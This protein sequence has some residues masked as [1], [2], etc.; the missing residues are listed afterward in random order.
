M[1]DVAPVAG[2]RRK[3]VSF[4]M[5][6][7]DFCFLLII[8]FVALLSVA[9]FDPTITDTLAVKRTASGAGVPMDGQDPVS[10]SG[11]PLPEV[12]D[13]QAQQQALSAAQA[14]ALSLSEELAGL[15]EEKSH[16]QQQLAAL[17]DSQTTTADSLAQQAHRAAASE[18]ELNRLREQVEELRVKVRRLEEERKVLEEALEKARQ[19]NA[20]HVDV[21]GE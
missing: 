3:R 17:V 10:T 21:G 13:P 19:R 7:V 4:L 6:F 12:F 5:P 11:G 1:N 16:I 9:Y 14:V 2:T 20:I 15:E 8:L 18:H